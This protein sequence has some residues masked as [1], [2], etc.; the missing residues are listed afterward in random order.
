MFQDRAVRAA[1]SDSAM[2]TFGAHYPQS[3]M[4]LQH[5]LAHHPM[6]NMYA[7]SN[8]AARLPAKDVEQR[9]ATDAN[10]QNFA[11]VDQ[12]PVRASQAIVNMLRNPCWVMLRDIQQN[13]DYANLLDQIIEPLRDQ[14]EDTTGAINMLRGFI[15]MSAPGTLTPLHFDPEFNI[16]MQI[17]GQKMFHTYPAASPFLSGPQQE[18]FHANGDNILPWGPDYVGTGNPHA[19]NP[20]DALF[21][22]YK[23]PHWVKV[24][25]NAPS[26]SLS[27]TWRTEYCDRLDHAVQLRR[28]LRR[29]GLSPNTPALW[30]ADH[31]ASD[32]IYRLLRKAGIR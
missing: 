20:G 32:L 30:P 21:V 18:N 2:A 22:P 13:P 12:D 16:L 1:W 3:N 23:A 28:I 26:I 31:R 9:S 27:I 7:L 14:I 5:G 8:L 25:G 11:H 29:I 19:L 24:K 6:L 15:F 17:S 10:P 4:G